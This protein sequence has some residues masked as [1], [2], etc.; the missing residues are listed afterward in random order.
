MSYACAEIKRYYSL[1]PLATKEV[2]SKMPF[3][4]QRF[5]L[6]TPINS[7]L[8]ALIPST[9]LIPRK[10]FITNFL[11]IK[12][13]TDGVVPTYSSEGYLIHNR[14]CNRQHVPHELNLHCFNLFSDPFKQ[15]F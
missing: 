4:Y 8:I 3:G 11:V 2:L 7:V 15:I 5:T 10:S 9:L 1:K 13:N 12:S 6:F 14:H